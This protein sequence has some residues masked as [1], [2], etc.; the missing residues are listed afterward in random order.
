[1]DLNQATQL[2][3]W[4]DE[5]HRKDKALLM[6]LQSQVEVQ[7]AQLTEQARQV[8]EIQAA[9]ARIEGQLPKLEQ[10][11]IAIQGFRTEFSGLMA[12]QSA[13]QEGLQGKRL[14]A[15]K[16]GSE[17]IARV[18]RQVQDRVDALGTYENTITV[19]RDEDG[20]LRSQLTEAFDQ[21]SDL[22]KRV[23]V[24]PPRLAR[25]E[26][27]VP[28]FGDRL[29]DSRLAI[30]DLNN[31]YLQLKAEVDALVPSQNAK[32]D[33]TQAALQELRD[34]QRP[35][36][37]GLRVKHQDQAR[38]IDELDQDFKAIQTPMARWARQLEEFA[39]QFERNSKT[40]HDLR[41]LERTVRQQGKETIELQ[42]IASER[43]RTDM[44]EW[45]DSQVRVDE[46]QNVRLQQLEAGLPRA[47]E[48]L[49]DLED[50]LQQN[51][52]ALE[53]YADEFWQAWSTY[54]QGQTSL[55]DSMVRQRGKD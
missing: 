49:R 14:Q 1:M 31:R 23:D 28:G 15:E 16:Q 37:D 27:A 55:F 53:D 50:R 7:K 52:Q 24:Q 18:I 38:R 17:A 21:I 22:S 33:Q 46:E 29:A 48:A 43:Q 44:R 42:R 40:I 34:R 54:M 45:Q 4:L 25:L 30:E 47:T 6:A 8:Q 19:L 5:E 10:L 35:E 39:D 3:S 9:L 20:K 13:E 11:D 41:E 51:R 12:K 2:L 36:L 26:Q 32:I